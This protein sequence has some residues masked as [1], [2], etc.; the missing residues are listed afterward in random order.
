MNPLEK[1][2]CLR[3]RRDVLLSY[4]ATGDETLQDHWTCPHE[5][6]LA[7]HPSTRPGHIVLAY[8]AAGP[9]PEDAA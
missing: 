5:D 9:R 4:V 8:P 1:T 3:C 6:C 7:K 2:A